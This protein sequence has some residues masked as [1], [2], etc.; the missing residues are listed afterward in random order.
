MPS[1]VPTMQDGA[2]PPVPARR[3]RRLIAAALLASGAGALGVAQLSDDAAPAAADAYGARFHLT[4]QSDERRERA[5]CEHV[6]CPAAADPAAI[7][8]RESVH[9]TRTF[10]LVWS[11][12]VPAD[13]A[14]PPP[15]TSP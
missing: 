14:A 10:T 6:A 7:P 8:R 2:P 15:T 11:A 9:R 12:R 5:V 13:A 1:A 3:L 4:V